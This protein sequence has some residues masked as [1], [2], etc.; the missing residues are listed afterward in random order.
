MIRKF[1]AVPGSKWR[2]SKWRWTA[3]SA[4][5]SSF[6]MILAGAATLVAQQ[7]PAQPPTQ[8]A[9]AQPAAAQKP[10][11]QQPN[12]QEASPEES[13]SRRKVKPRDYK[14]WSFNVG[15]GASVDN[16]AT[17]TYVRGGG[18]VAAAG[19]ARNYSKYFGLRADF[20]WDNLPL[21]NSALQLAQARSA[22]SQAYT[23]MVD[24]IINIP[25][26]TNWG[27]YVLFGPSYVHRSGTLDSST[28]LPGS[29][30]NGFFVWWGACFNGSL[31]INGKFLSES[32]NEFGFNFGGG[33]TRKITPRVELYAE[34]RYVRGTH[35]G[36]QT[37]FRPIT[38]GLRW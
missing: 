6:F 15:G 34:F 5:P 9:P 3:V 16:G 1:A 13:T 21:R 28:A 11:T 38:L 14:N 26:T 10:D 19:V 12:S 29:A 7:A 18:V 35:S 2:R 36:I 37:A 20:Q 17:K 22:T 32:Q 33:I 25:V 27:G 4:I 31:P 24:P 23:V 8:Q 30:C